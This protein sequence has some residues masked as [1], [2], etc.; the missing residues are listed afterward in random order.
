MTSILFPGVLVLALVSPAPFDGYARTSLAGYELVWRGWS[1]GDRLE[2]QGRIPAALAAVEQS[3][4]RRLD[5]R[6]TVAL[7][8]DGFELASV[9]RGLTGEE[10]PPLRTRGVA[11]P[12]QGLLLLRGGPLR[13][14]GDLDQ[15]LRHELAHLVVHTRATGRVPRWVDKGIACAVS[16]TRLSPDEEARLALL[17]HV[18]GL[19]SWATLEREFPRTEDPSAIAYAQSL[20]FFERLTARWGPGAI[21]TLLDRLEEGDDVPS[22]LERLTHLSPAA[23]EADFR[24]WVAARQSLFSALLQGGLGFWWIAGLLA[25]LAAVRYLLRRR[26]YRRLEAELPPAEPGA[27]PP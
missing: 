24:A 12:G 14:P 16:G 26:R 19:Y 11:I 9:V 23:V 2:L 27:A 21:P 3:L 1:E 4:G 18:G 8:P 15:T 22:A 13:G 7:V 20:L 17:A 6:F 10:V 25:V 5:R